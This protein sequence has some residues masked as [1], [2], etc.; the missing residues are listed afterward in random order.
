[1]ADGNFIVAAV[2][3]RSGEGL[4]GKGV[5]H[6]RCCGTMWEGTRG[7]T[8]MGMREKDEQHRMLEREKRRTVLHIA[9]PRAVSE[10][11]PRLP[12]HVGLARCAVLAVPR[13]GQAG[14]QIATS[15]SLQLQLIAGQ[16]E[17]PSELAGGRLRLRLRGRGTT[18]RLALGLALG[19]DGGTLGGSA[20]FPSHGGRG[21]DGWNMHLSKT[22]EGGS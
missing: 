6:T 2:A 10:R 14:M 16:V 20:S 8:T 11:P 15:F 17:K 22:S 4:E 5:G 1:M 12:V 7:N 3:G 19:L 21:K 18:D 13:H 9:R